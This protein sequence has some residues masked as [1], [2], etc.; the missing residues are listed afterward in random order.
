[1]KSMGVV[2]LIAVLMFMA[3]DP[4]AA[5]DG[6][7]YTNPLATLLLLPFAVAATIT[8]GVATVLT[9]PFTYP[10]APYPA[11]YAYPYSYRYRGPYWWYSPAPY[12]SF[13]PPYFYVPPRVVLQEPP[14][15]IQPPPSP[16]PQ[17]YWHYCA[18]AEAYY[19]TVPTCPEAWIKVL[20]R[21][22]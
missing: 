1:M 15:P 11:G 7:V 3:V 18:S 14:V 10:N 13:P 17:S 22:Q 20:P 2:T 8:V 9:A 19:P 4:A 16:A 5:Q 21:P 12:Y 6:G